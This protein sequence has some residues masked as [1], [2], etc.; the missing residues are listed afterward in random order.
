M[1]ILDYTNRVDCSNGHILDSVDDL[2][3]FGYKNLFTFK[4]TLIIRDDEVMS[5]GINDL[6]KYDYNIVV[7]PTTFDKRKKLYKECVKNNI[8]IYEPEKPIS[9]FSILDDLILDRSMIGVYDEVFEKE[10]FLKILILL[11][12]QVSDTLE[13]KLTNKKSSWK[14]KN[15]INM[16]IDKLIRV[17][18]ALNKAIVDT[19]TYSKINYKA[20]LISVLEEV[21]K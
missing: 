10:G 19:K 15:F 6:E 17:S 5:L 11:E 18:E 1:I 4:D 13:I 16:P 21:F 14:H 20:E 7:Q 8:K 12:R 3:N 9:I 2:V